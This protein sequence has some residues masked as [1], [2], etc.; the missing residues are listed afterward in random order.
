MTSPT[1]KCTQPGCAGTIEG[2]Y[3][4]ICGVAQTSAS[5]G[6]ADG[7]CPNC[8]NKYSFSPKL[9][10]G[11]TA[12]A[13]GDQMVATRYFR[14]VLTVDRSFVSAAFGLARTLLR[15]GDRAGAIA[16]LSVVPDSSSHHVAAQIAAIRVLVSPPPGQACVSAADLQEAG[17]GVGILML[18]QTAQ[19]QL[20]AEVL[21]AALAR[22]HAGEAPDGV[23]LLGCDNNE[24]SLRFGLERTYRTQAQLTPDRR[25]RTE[26]VDLANSVRPSTWS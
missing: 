24:R 20:I 13:T 16:A 9:G 11:D 26:L 3:C 12:E 23:K 4:D 22:L 8:G 5:T 21:K 7:F 14:L 19:Q 6:L 15:A 2:G 17:Q 25:R 1:A 10:K 18:D